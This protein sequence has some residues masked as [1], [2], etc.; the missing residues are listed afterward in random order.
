MRAINSIKKRVLRAY[1]YLINY[2]YIYSNLNII[3]NNLQAD[4]I[5][6]CSF[7]RADINFTAIKNKKIIGI[8]RLGIENRKRS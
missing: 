7:G 4:K 6:F 1:K 8:V 2:R 5:L 3:K